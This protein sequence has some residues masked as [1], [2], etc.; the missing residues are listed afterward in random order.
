MPNRICG[1][2]E[3]SGGVTVTTPFAEIVYTIGPEHHQVKITYDIRQDHFRL[4]V[5]GNGIPV[6]FKE[7]FQTRR[8]ALREAQR[9]IS[10]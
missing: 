9:F 3:I 6:L 8:A 1:T 4:L 5:I 2:V 7:V 10:A